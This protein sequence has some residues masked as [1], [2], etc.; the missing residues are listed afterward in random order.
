MKTCVV[1]AL[2]LMA[3]VSLGD[4]QKRVNNGRPCTADETKSFVFINDCSGTVID[5]NWVI[6]AGHCKGRK[7]LSKKYDIK[8]V[9]LNLKVTSEK[10]FPHKTAD[11]MLIKGNT[12]MTGMPLVSEADCD[13]VMKQISPTK[14]VKMVIPAKDTQAKK[15][16]GKLASM[17]ADIK[18]DRSG[19]HPITKENCV[20]WTPLACNSCEGDSGAGYIYNNALFA[21]HSGENEYTDN[22][23]K[24]VKV[25]NVGHIVCNGDIRN[26]IVNTM[27]NNP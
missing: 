22:K 7:K 10:T 21:V 17:C 13:Q 14:P 19:P 12:G 24:V 9:N 5:G 25:E 6:T 2:F 23:G 11:V 1:L 15:T 4:I 26:W 8:D 16:T 20:Y 3:G 18:V 27:N